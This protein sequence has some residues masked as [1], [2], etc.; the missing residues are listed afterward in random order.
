MKYRL[1]A[2]IIA[3]ACTGMT[4]AEE[5]WWP[6]K[7]GQD[8]TMGSFNMLGPELTLKA[9]KLI[10]TGKTYRLGIETNDETPAFPPR[11][12]NIHIV[13]PNQYNGDAYGSNKFNFLDDIIAGW[14]GVG[15][16]IDGLGH[17]ATD[18]VFYNG[19][20][21]RDFAKV[22]GVTKFGMEDLPPIVTRGVLLDMASCMGKDM[23]P[24]GTP[25]T[26]EDIAACEKKQGISIEKGDVVLFHSG[27]LEIIESDPVRFAKAEPGLGISGAEYLVAKDVMA[28]GADTWGLEVLPPEKEDVLYKVH[29][30]LITYNG[31]YILENMD[32]RALAAD[33]AYEFMFV[34]GPARM[35]G[36]VQMI[37]NPIAIR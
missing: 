1:F 21:A 11:T 15:S 20:L 32:T 5:K 14:I 36:T 17:A 25:Y 29:Q 9:A 13:Y 24:E 34:L 27:W 31:I 28:V 7:W 37:I 30:I 4:S 8:D 18:G 2:V 33:K 16:Q 19:N 12:F 22:D 6:S 35:T 23:L 3:L 26:G 10:K